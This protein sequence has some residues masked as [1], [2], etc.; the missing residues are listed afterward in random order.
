[1]QFPFWHVVG[2]F[3]FLFFGPGADALAA[4]GGTYK[5]HRLLILGLGRVGLECGLLATQRL[6]SLDAVIGTVRSASKIHEDGIQRIPFQD[7]SIV[8]EHLKKVT[9]VLWTIPLPKERDEHLEQLLDLVLLQQSSTHSDNYLEWIGFVSTTGVYGNHNGA[10]VT[11]DS[12]LL[13][14]PDSNANL[15]RQVE[16]RFIEVGGQIFRCAGIYDST[17]SALHTVY[18]TGK[19][20][21]IP[22]SKKAM[23]ALDSS[24]PTNRIHT[25]DIARAIVASMNRQSSDDAERRP[26]RIYNLA[27]DEPEE[28]SVVLQY[29]ADLLQSIGVELMTVVVEDDDDDNDYKSSSQQQSVE[30]L[31]KRQR[32]RLSDRKLVSNQRMKSEL[33]L[34]D[35]GDLTYP[36]YRE[37]LTAILN[38]SRTPWW[39]PRRSNEQG[40]KDGKIQ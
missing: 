35:A 19:R 9:H 17:R 40:E 3:W 6:S 23:G 28:R 29:A 21:S 38:D 8:Q 20:P 1:M 33:L 36:S 27:D 18:K 11:E 7:I 12:S 37:G 34:E 31:T 24:F 14:T 30:S 4:V 15:Y 2:G 32:R 22:P 5:T 10:H 26:S 39:Q 16:Q 13:C 25:H